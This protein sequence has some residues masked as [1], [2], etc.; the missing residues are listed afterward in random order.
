MGRP[1]DRS[2]AFQRRQG[3]RIALVLSLLIHGL[4][5]GLLFTTEKATT[6]V[7]FERT[8]IRFKVLEPK[9][10]KEEKWSG[11]IVDIPPPERESEPPK[12]ARFLS[13]YNTKVEREQKAKVRGPKAKKGGPGEV[14]SAGEPKKAP[15]G[16][17]KGEER[18]IL[19]GRE[20]LLAKGDPLGTGLSFGGGGI[21]GLSKSPG[22]GGDSDDALL[23][24]DREGDTTLVN[25]RSF[26]YWDF[27]QRVKERV[28]QEWNPVA[29]YRAR[30]PYGEIY[31]TRDRLTILGVVLDKEGRIERL[32][33]VRPSGLP[34]LDEEAIR[35]FREAAPF[36]NPP[37]GLA[38]ESG[39][40]AFHFGF[41]LD[42]SSSRA[43]F[44]WQRP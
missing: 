25:S 10:R 37:Q 7:A 11:Q 34:F 18:G 43:R 42:F 38:D 35:A 28:R 23:G 26:K 16:S 9:A 4:M 32:E 13:R 15:P 19:P 39:H 27:F 40:I 30:D 2:C 41:I 33:V 1:M 14:A 5:L 22:P 24:V 8:P 20:A 12:D 17:P 29:V 21:S 6:R 36:P 44:F 31:G 3:F